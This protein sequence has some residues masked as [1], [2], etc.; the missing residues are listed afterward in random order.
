MVINFLI[1]G[2]DFLLSS[3]GTK[4][5]GG[6]QETKEQG[7]QLLKS[8]KPPEPTQVDQERYFEENPHPQLSVCNFSY[9]RRPLGLNNEAY[10]L[11]GL[12]SDLFCVKIVFVCILYLF[13][14]V[15][16]AR[17]GLETR[18]TRAADEKKKKVGL[19]LL[20]LL[21]LGF[22]LL[23][24]IHLLLLLSSYPRATAR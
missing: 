11:V 5:E 8:L 4:E 13:L 21:L 16:E 22:L 17:A 3:Q 9:V 18:A 20:D 1:S 15:R 24:L 23:L 6:G 7:G 2:R 19:L 10:E 12:I 14:Q